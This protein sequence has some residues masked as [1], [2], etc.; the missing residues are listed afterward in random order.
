MKNAIVLILIVV[1]GLT[2]SFVVNPPLNWISDGELHE[3][4]IAMRDY[5]IAQAEKNGDY[6]CCID[7]VCTMCYMEGNKWNYGEAGKCFC[8][9]FIARGEEACPQCERGLVED[10]GTS[11]EV[12]S[13]K[14]ET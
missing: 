2:V 9:E 10:T 11:C 1:I 8:D 6:L 5:G 14:C 7:P 13:Q 4:V 12:L 3:K